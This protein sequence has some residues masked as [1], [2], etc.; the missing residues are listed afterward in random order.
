MR[1][2]YNQMQHKSKLK[3]SLI[4][5]EKNLNLN[6]NEILKRARNSYTVSSFIPSAKTILHS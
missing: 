6:L 1:S 4:W 3:I 2:I 5:Q